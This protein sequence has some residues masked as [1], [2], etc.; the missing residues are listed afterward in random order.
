MVFGFHCALRE[1]GTTRIFLHPRRKQKNRSLGELSWAMI[2]NLRGSEWLMT[3]VCLLYPSI[4]GSAI[5]LIRSKDHS[6]FPPNL[7]WLASQAPWQ[8][9][10][11]KSQVLLLSP[12]IF[13]FFNCLCR[14]CVQFS[15]VKL[16]ALVGSNVQARCSSRI[17]RLFQ[18]VSCPPISRMS[19]PP[20]LPYVKRQLLLMNFR[21]SCVKP[22]NRTNSC[23]L[24][25]SNPFDK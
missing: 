21:F 4:F 15:S 13:V 10:M 19:K 22:E 12:I 11:L 3:N 17:T 8:F 1:P 14:L 9:L 23:W 6:V 20:F 25:C 18:V 7:R 16:P 2:L 24:N 5:T